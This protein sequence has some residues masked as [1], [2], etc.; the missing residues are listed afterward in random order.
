MWQDLALEQMHEEEK[1]AQFAKLED[2]AK[3]VSFFPSDFFSG[4]DRTTLALQLQRKNHSKA[5]KE[6][7]EEQFQREIAQERALQQQILKHHIDQLAVDASKVN[8]IESMYLILLN[9][10]ILRKKSWQTYNF[11]LS[12]ILWTW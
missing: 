12:I 6:D 3:R 11:W 1:K 10:D 7:L 2:R 4:E 8:H 9:I 5:S